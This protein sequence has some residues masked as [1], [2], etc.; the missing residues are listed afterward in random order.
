M[1]ANELGL[2]QIASP[3]APAPMVYLTVMQAMFPV[4]P[5]LD[6]LRAHPKPC[7]P[8]RAWDV[9]TFEFPV[10][11]CDTGQKAGA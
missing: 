5:E 2:E 9:A 10:Q 6:H 1:M 11:L 7:P 3:S 8:R 4:R